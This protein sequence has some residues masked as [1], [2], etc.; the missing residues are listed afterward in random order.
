MLNAQQVW[1]NAAWLDANTQAPASLTLGESV[2]DGSVTKTYGT[3]ALSTVNE[4][5]AGVAA[6]GSIHIDPG[7]YVADVDISKD[8]SINSVGA[9]PVN[10]EAQSTA[11]VTVESGCTVS[12]SGI[13]IRNSPIGV[14]VN[15]GMVTISSTTISGNTIG[16]SAVGGSAVVTES[17]IFANTTGLRFAGGASGSIAG[18]SFADGMSPN[19]ETDLQLAPSAGAVTIGGGNAFA[20]ATTIDNQ[21][22]R[23]VDATAANSFAGVNLAELDPTTTSG[24]PGLFAIESTIRDGLDDSGQG[25]VRIKAGDLFIAASSEAEAAGSLPRAIGLAASGDTVFVQAGTYLANANFIDGSAGLVAGLDIDKPLSLIGPNAD[26]DPQTNTTPAHPQ[27][28][29]LPAVSDPDPATTSAES[30]VNVRANSVTIRGLTID[31]DNPALAAD[32]RTVIYHNAAI[33][34][35]DGISCCAGVGDL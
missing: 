5:V 1:I 6:G 16:V 21:T 34:A 4:G 9:G 23:L 14:R 24:L 20:G 15:G 7:T 22:A 10:L 19:N 17:Q 3:D 26:F 13:S 27:A 29:I 33:D 8:L 31:G 11:A 2:T 35:F 18:N 25:L 12:L 30:I 28:I 32:S